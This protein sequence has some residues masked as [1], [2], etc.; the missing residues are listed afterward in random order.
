MNF[1]SF[2]LHEVKLAEIQEIVRECNI[3][4]QKGDLLFLRVGIT[5][6]WDMKMSVA[7]KTEYTTKPV[8]ELAAA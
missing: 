8:P 4:I 2:T 5:C 1:N 6:D 7:E 3:T